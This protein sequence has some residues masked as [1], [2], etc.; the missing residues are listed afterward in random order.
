MTLTEFKAWFDGF[1]EEMKGAPTEKQ[2]KR[3]CKRVDEIDDKPIPKRIY[4][5]RYFDP[6]RRHYPLLWVAD[7]TPQR[8]WRDSR[9]KALYAAGQAEWASTRQG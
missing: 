5:D 8:A 3:I 2:W 7:S 6:Y 4:I 9:V 1:T